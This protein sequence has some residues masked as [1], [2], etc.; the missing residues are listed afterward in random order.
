MNL[1]LSL[2][3]YGVDISDPCCFALGFMTISSVLKLQGH[4][5]KVLNY[6][7][8]D[9]NFEDEI[10]NADAVLMTGFEEF[11]PTIKAQAKVCKDKGIQTILGGA[12]AT[13]KPLEMLE[14]VDTVVIGE[15]ETVL[16][17]ALTRKGVIYG[18][19]PEKPCIDNFPL[20][21]YHGFGIDEYNRRHSIRY[22]GVLTSRGCPYRC[23]FCVQTCN[24]QER[25]LSL[26]FEEIDGYKAEYGV[27]MIVFNDNTLNLRKERWMTLCEGMKERNIGW[28][29][30][31]RV[32]NFD[33]EMAKAAKESGLSYLVVGVESFKQSK[34]DE[35]NKRIKT[36][37]ITRQHFARS[38][39]G[40]LSGHI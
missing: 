26:V 39:G 35:M 4:D 29:A 33:E 15:G 36:E 25:N 6:N 1:V 2:P 38:T 8:W 19:E 17:E 40:N 11:L 18:N 31:I 30:A 20:P 34:L 32:D 7:L 13:F 14:Y 37:Q 24:F 12:L 16:H 28:G 5:V 23:K 3:K 27:E 21:D 22:M 10:E 9:Y